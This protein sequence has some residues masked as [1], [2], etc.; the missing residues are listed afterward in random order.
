[1]D[2]D[3][4][5]AHPLAGL[6]QQNYQAIRERDAALSAEVEQKTVERTQERQAELQQ[7]VARNMTGSISIYA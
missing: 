6:M 4:V 3:S 1:M 2:I 7:G 5:Y